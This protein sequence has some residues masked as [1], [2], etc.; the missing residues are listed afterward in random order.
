MQFVA[1]G[2]PSNG[3]DPLRNTDGTSGYG[4]VDY[5]FHIGKYEVSNEQYSRFLNAVAR[6]D[7]NGLYSPSMGSDAVGGIV[8]LGTPGN[9]TYMTK[10]ASANKPAVYV[11]FHQALRFCNWLHNGMPS[12]SQ[13]SATTEDGAYT[14]TAAGLAANTITRN[15]GARF[16]I[17]SEN[18]WYKAAYYDPA[19]GGSGGYWLYPTQSD[20]APAM[21][22]ADAI[23]NIRNQSLNVA[24]C[25]A[26]AVWNNQNGNV[27]TVGSG[28]PGSESAYGAADLGGNVWEWNE[29][30]IGSNR[31]LR[32]GCI[33]DYA[34]TLGANN[35]FATNPNADFVGL[36]F[37]VA[38]P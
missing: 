12:G 9:Y 36:G 20:S 31:G 29:A 11:R 15:P 27:T 21:A 37:R 2:N 22:L 10:K 30:I 33:Y 35:R 38:A 8:R 23:G 19:R 14:I 26:G 25:L 24:N 7:L 1:I 34:E 17:P 18:E 32:G 3:G 13:E 28:G 4:S 6:T 16:F 5:S